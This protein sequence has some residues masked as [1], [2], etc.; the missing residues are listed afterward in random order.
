MVCFLDINYDLNGTPFAMEDLRAARQWWL[1]AITQVDPRWIQHPR[2]EFG[3][4]WTSPSTPSGVHVI[5]LAR[6]F[7]RLANMISPECQRPLGTKLRQLIRAEG[8]QY[9]ELQ[10]E[11]LAGHALGTSRRPL[12][13]EPRGEESST[14]REATGSVDFAVECTDTAVYVEATVFHVQQ[15]HDWRS[16]VERLKERFQR[17]M[18]EQRCNR[19]LLISAPLEIGQQRLEAGE[20]RRIIE[21]MQLNEHGKREIAVGSDMLL[22][23]WSPTPHFPS[24]PLE[25]L[26]APA[27]G[28]FATF[29][30]VKV[31][32]VAA[33]STFLKW[34]GSAEELLVKSL[35]HTLDRKRKQFNRE[36][37]YAIALRSGSD[38]LKDGEIT[39]MLLERVFKNPLYKWI[40]GV[41]LFGLSFSQDT[42]FTAKPVIIP[43]AKAVHPLPEDLVDG[44][45][46]RLE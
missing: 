1:R 10:F 21:E 16:E 41:F 14:G 42:G 31:V 22:L 5:S 26:A 39:Y 12:R 45:L 43:N 18:T 25:A 38:L 20:I 33:T 3:V 8:N 46:G 37:P 9:K 23:E 4:H 28:G 44:L 30:N 40:S 13:L 6:S 34:P 17:S 15:L 7:F 29:G 32:A 24:G 35:R 19:Q 27:K 2:G 36:A 11:L